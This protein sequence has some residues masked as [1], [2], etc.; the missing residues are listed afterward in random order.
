MNRIFRN[1]VIVL[2]LFIY[3]V[4][5][6]QKDP[7]NDRPE[8]FLEQLN[9]P[10]SITLTH[11]M[12]MLSITFTHNNYYED[13]EECEECED[14]A[15]EVINGPYEGTGYGFEIECM[16]DP[17]D[18]KYDAYGYG[19]YKFYNNRSGSPP[20]YID[21][22]DNNYN[23]LG[24]A[25]TDFYLRYNYTT[26]S[27]EIKPGGPNGVYD[28]I[29]NEELVT[30]WDVFDATEPVE[31]SDFP[32][33][34]SSCLVLIKK[35]NNPRI[36]WGSHPTFSATNYKVY[37]AVST[38]PLSHPEIFASLISTVSSTTFDYRDVNINVNGSD[39][40]Y[41]FVKAYNSGS[42][43]YSSRTNIVNTKGGFYKQN[44]KI[45]NLTEE[46]YKYNLLPNYPN[47]FNPSTNITYQ[48]PKKGQVVLKIYNALGKE[49]AELVNETKEE[50][51]YSVTFNGDNLPSGMYFYK[52]QCGEFIDVK[53]MLLLK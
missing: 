28:S 38:L 20:F 1:I 39:Y 19:L 37:R 53:K 31:T 52:I 17:K 30:I 25:G 16:R 4:L 22:R 35:Y 48:L 7:E 44:K 29:G 42:N 3:T 2:N 51:I 8:L 45:V 26:D 50:G 9:V 47:P 36:V 40:I 14:P 13:W 41:Y 46:V 23:Q 10:S 33:F 11:Y 6:G 27:Y 24:Y 32:N 12:D 21:I 43:S 18:V 49:V 34:W 5:F 15:I